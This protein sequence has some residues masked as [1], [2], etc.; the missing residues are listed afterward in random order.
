LEKGFDISI[1]GEAEESFAEIVDWLEGRVSLGSIPGVSFRDSKG[2]LH[3]NKQPAQVG[4]LDRLPV[5]LIA[6]RLFD[7][8]WYG[9]VDPGIAPG[10]ILFSRGCPGR[11]SFCANYVA[12][13]QP[14]YRTPGKVVEELEGYHE[15]TGTT[16][17]SFWDN[18]ITADQDKLLGL[19]ETLER[20]ASFDVGWSA[21]TRVNLITP[22]LLRAM[23][24]AGCVSIN[25]GA[26]SG[27]DSILRAVGKNITRAEV[28]RALTWSKAEGLLTSCSFMLGFPYDTPET[29]EGTLRFLERISPLVDSFSTLGLVIPFPGTPLYNKFHERY[30]FTKWWLNDRYTRHSSL[31][32]ID[33]LDRFCS[34]YADDVNLELDFFQYSKP[35]RQAIKACLKF[36]AEHNLRNMGLRVGGA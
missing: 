26:E 31:P 13:R 25:F 8:A 12:G 9:F 14:R 29:L 3:Q 10:G 30:G 17:F 20:E 33:D 2:L 34:Q 11:C 16:F 4:N 21:I 24:S 27:D 28:I 5:P 1:A 32:P 18:A 35:M 6:E 23:R 15:R 19:C 36:K 22:K 7:P